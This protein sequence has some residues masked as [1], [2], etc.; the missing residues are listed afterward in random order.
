MAAD[1]QQRQW[2]QAEAHAVG[3]QPELQIGA[4]DFQVHRKVQPLLG[5]GALQ[6]GAE[7]AAIRVEHPAARL[8]LGQAAITLGRRAERRHHDQVHAGQR[9]P[10]QA[11]RKHLARRKQSGHGIQ[12]TV[13]Q[14]LEQ[15]AAPT[16]GHL[17][18]Q[19]RVGGLQ[20]LQRFQ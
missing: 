16:I 19:F 20:A 1:L 5:Q 13:L 7:A 6:A 9:L 8:A 4:E 17:H 18:M 12:F 2:H 10:H 3:H 14:A 15:T 11:F